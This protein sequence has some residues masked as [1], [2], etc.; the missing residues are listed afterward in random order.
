M[1]NQPQAPLALLCSTLLF[2]TAAC[3]QV[4]SEPSKDLQESAP[5][6]VAITGASAWI[7]PDQRIDNAT[8]VM[9]D[10][11]IV[12]VTKAGAVPA[13]ATEIS[14]KGKWILPGFLDAASSYGLDASANC[15]G[16]NARDDAKPAAQTP[17][18]QQAKHWNAAVCAER[19]LSQ[20]LHL[21]S[22]LAKSWNA[23]GFTAAITVPSKGVW[24]GQSAALFIRPDANANASVYKTKL[25]QIAAMQRNGGFGLEYPA[26]TMGAI[27]L[28]RQSLYDARWQAS[29]SSLKQANVAL[30]ALA[31]VSRGQQTLLMET[32]DELEIARAAKLALEFGLKMQ[33]I[34]SG[35]EYRLLSPQV[36]RSAVGQNT[37]ELPKMP[38]TLPL[39]FPEAPAV[40]TGESA[41]E[42]S[43]AELEH[44]QLAVE[45]PARLANQGVQIAL[46]PRGLVKPERKFLKNL[47]AVIAAGLS[48]DQAIAALSTTPASFSGVPELSGLRA[49]YVANVL[50]VSPDWLVSEQGILHEVWTAGHRSV[51]APLDK[52]SFVGEY[53]LEVAGGKAEKTMTIS[54]DK[55]LLAKAGTHKL[56]VSQK[57]N[58]LQ[59]YLPGRWF[60]VAEEHV[61]FHAHRTEQGFD[62]FASTDAGVNLRLVATRIDAATKIDASSDSKLPNEIKRIADDRRYPAGEFGR[63]GIPNQAN[64]VF[65]NATIWMHDISLKTASIADT[66]VWIKNGQ[67][68][69]VGRQL[70]VDDATQVVD[71]S[72]MH[73]SPGLID[74]HSHIAV[75]GDVNEGT[76]TVTSEVRIGDVLDP[77][78]IN[79]YRQLA[80][81]LTSAHVL[82]GSAN[83]IGGQSQLI[84]LRWGQN[85]EALKFVEALPTIKFALGENPKQANWGEQFVTRYP[86]TRMGV[87]Q[88]IE[89]SFAQAKRYADADPKTRRRDLR[90][91][92]IAEI[93]VEKR[94]IHAHSYRQDEIL[95]L[96][97]MTQKLG[98]QIAAFQHVL[99]GYKVA[100]VLA[101][102]G[103][104]AST[105][106][107]WWAFK[108]E[109]IDAIPYNAAL[110]T[111]AGVLTSLNSDS[112]DHARRLNT[113]A[114][115]MIR[116]GGLSEAQALALVTINPAK[117]LRID[118]NVGSIS[119]GKHADLVLWSAPPLSS[120]ARVLQTWI[121]GRKYFDLKDDQAERARI[122]AAREALIASARLERVK[123]LLEKPVE[124]KENKARRSL[125]AGMRMP[126]AWPSVLAA[127][128]KPY[129]NGEPVHICTGND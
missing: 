3:A 21:D 111:R 87:E 103:A 27:A 39:N 6:F 67:I 74:A 14:A 96:A 2:A 100:D 48:Q 99:E 94:L 115:K 22:K 12:S 69:A 104:G 13:G 5:D 97:R 46:T 126:R 78:D 20:V 120:R 129:H 64:V 124:P 55:S 57:Q 24:R 60:G 93:L 79:I 38:I 34:G 62:A 56:V 28:I 105:F 10:G 73:I 45:N 23:M 72:A 71:A 98:I 122:A 70:K 40:E 59:L 61:P 82:H 123:S 53:Q 116:F 81:G 58:R 76:H 113:E 43:L 92:A 7:A 90:L 51:L 75:A 9:R 121:D 109:V 108:A 17:T 18:S 65:R 85:A 19:D 36:A 30:E 106:A 50:I 15:G 119:V 1:P 26:S 114:A 128:R 117:Q 37:T 32:T 11:R 35:F 63:V 31:A 25:A 29:T 112:P 4:S 101:E 33:L 110:M 107:D 127:R 125:L 47:R 52:I 80:G 118:Q 89:D 42:V 44:W 68:A 95:M 49:G 66:D 8:L 86:Q 54:E 41:L 88:L 16:A 84:K 91:E 77:T 102:V 83:A